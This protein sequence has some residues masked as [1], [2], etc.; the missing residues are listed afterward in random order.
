MVRRRA[1]MRKSASSAGPI[2]LTTSRSAKAPAPRLVFGALGLF[3]VQ[4]LLDVLGIHQGHDAV[5]FKNFLGDVVHKERLRD[6]CRVSHAGG[7]DDHRVQLQ[8]LRDALGKL[9]E[10]R[11]EILPHCAAD[12]SVEHFNDFVRRLRLHVL[13]QQ[14]IVDAYFSE[15]VFDDRYLLAVLRGEDVVQ[16]GCLTTSEEARQDCHGHLRSCLRSRHSEL[17]PKRRRFL[18]GSYS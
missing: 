6:R 3:G 10:D 5:K 16:E 9:L 18:V 4:V 11:Y 13:L 12:A 1:S 8:T 17:S 15:L 2:L 7:L 14:R